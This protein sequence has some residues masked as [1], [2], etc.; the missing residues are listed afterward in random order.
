[1]YLIVHV[2]ER[3]SVW[4][5]SHMPFATCPNGR[6]KAE[7]KGWVCSLPCQNDSP[8]QSPSSYKLTYQYFSALMAPDSNKSCRTPC[9][10]HFPALSKVYTHTRT[11]T[12]THTHTH[13]RRK[14]TPCL[15]TSMGDGYWKPVT[16]LRNIWKCW[17]RNFHFGSHFFL[18]WDILVLCYRVMWQV[19]QA[20]QETKSSNFMLSWSACERCSCVLLFDL[21]WS[22]CTEVFPEAISPQ[23]TMISNAKKKKNQIL[24]WYLVCAEWFMLMD[25]NLN[26]THRSDWNLAH[27]LFT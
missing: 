13:Q 27:Y 17:V 3:W 11:H 26:F 5:P 12:H 8:C 21:M 19:G 10:F 24:K 14:L 9:T 1:M 18:F 22:E 4:V 23:K 2:R 6:V 20:P 15:Q 25:R 7:R 16:N